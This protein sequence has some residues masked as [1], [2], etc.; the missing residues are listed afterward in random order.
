M[1][2][3]KISV[4]K[5]KQAMGR[6]PSGVTIVTTINNDGQRCGF[7]ASAFSSLSLSP[8]LILVC[9]ANNADCFDSFSTGKQFVVSIIGPEHEAL[10]FKFATKD[11]D[12][13]EGNEFVPGASG[14]P[15]LSNN[16]V[17]LECN[18]KYTY[19]GGDHVIL[20]GQVEHLRINDE[21]PSIWYEGKFRYLTD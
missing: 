20:V 13:F 5:F 21:N 4:D 19:P 17:S 10:A 16:P 7:T 1:N 12:K 11:S 3:N 2:T 14:L 9:L 18:T 15:I 8:P 6:F